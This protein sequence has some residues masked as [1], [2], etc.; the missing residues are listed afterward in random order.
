MQDT[1]YVSLE[2]KAG[3]NTFLKLCQ[4]VKRNS[5]ITFADMDLLSSNRG[6]SLYIY[7]SYLQYM[8]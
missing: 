5:V 3:Q 7:V 8:M 4:F 6:L 1:L 2:I